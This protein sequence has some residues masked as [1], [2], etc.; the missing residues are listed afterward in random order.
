MGGD[1]VTL[2]ELTQRLGI[3]EHTIRMLARTRGLP[4]YRL[5]AQLPPYAF[6]SE[7]EAWLKKQR[8]PAFHAKACQLAKSP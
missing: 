1:F 6:W 2:T 7:V 3:S 8:R 5:S 4:L